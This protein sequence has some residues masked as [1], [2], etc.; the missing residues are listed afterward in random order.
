MVFKG[1]LNEDA[2]ILQL[3]A[4]LQ[5]RTPNSHKRNT[6]ALLALRFNATIALKSSKKSDTLTKEIPVYVTQTEAA[7]VGINVG[8][9]RHYNA[10][11]TC[12]SAGP[13]ATADREPVSISLAEIAKTIPTMLAPACSGVSKQLG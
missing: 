2:L 7:S 13:V 5:R 4:R 6:N 10:A 12:E 1:I 8:F 3:A 9:V 11:F